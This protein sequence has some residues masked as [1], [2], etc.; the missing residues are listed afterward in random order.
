[1]ESASDNELKRLIEL[2]KQGKDLPQDEVKTTD[3]EDFVIEHFIPGNKSISL[4]VIK[5]YVVL[6]FEGMYTDKELRTILN[7]NYKWELR[8]NTKRYFLDETTYD[9]LLEGTKSVRMRIYEKRKKERA[10]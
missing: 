4:K 7:A 9:R 1:M 8:Y 3:L 10:S 2:A 5:D 6:H